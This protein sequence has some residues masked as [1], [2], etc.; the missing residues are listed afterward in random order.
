MKKVIVYVG[1]FFLALGFSNCNKT[2]E[3]ELSDVNVQSYFLSGIRP[4]YFRKLNFDSKEITD[5]I[6]I[7][8]QIF[9]KTFD[10]SEESYK[11]GKFKSSNDLENYRLLM[12]YY[13]FYIT[14]L[15]SNYLDQNFDFKTINGDNRIGLFSR[16]EDGE[17]DFE[18]KELNAMITEAYRIARDAYTINGYNDRAYGFFVLV[19]QIEKRFKRGD[20]LNDPI[21]HKLASDF[22]SYNLQ[23]LKVI[24]VWNLL[25]PM[26]VFTNYKD[27]LNTF[28]NRE[29]ETILRTYDKRLVVPGTLPDIGGKF[30]EILGPIYKFDVNL[31]KIDW[32]IE[33]QKGEWSAEELEKFDENLKTMNMITN[34]LELQKSKLLNA[35]PYRASYQKRKEMLDEIRIYRNNINTYPK[36]ELKH[37]INSVLFKKA[38]QCYSCHAN[39][40]MK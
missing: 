33:Q 15:V 32:T 34:Y 12:Q 1:I 25:M 9:K 11:N 19:N 24:P 36:P 8:L 39:S 6:P 37:G 18:N 10:S 21:A 40:N 28:T 22:V 16:I 7:Y 30:P 26:V 27:P 35:W 29:M 38:Y 31:K 4:D 13:S 17:K 3:Q 2:D 20:N 23:D 14:A 5:S